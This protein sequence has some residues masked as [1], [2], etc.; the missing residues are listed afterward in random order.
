MLVDF[1]LGVWDTA[2]VGLAHYFTTDGRHG[3]RPYRLRQDGVAADC[4][5]LPAR[6][7][8]RSCGRG[9]AFA[10]DVRSSPRVFILETT[11]GLM[12]IYVHTLLNIPDQTRQTESSYMARMYRLIPYT[13]SDSI[14]G[15]SPHN[16]LLRHPGAAD[17]PV[18]RLWLK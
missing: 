12:L 15:R 7:L 13:E 14:S 6:L 10:Y 9:F 4:A 11:P 18:R 2:I 5:R 17:T 8:S 3:G 16:R 1:P